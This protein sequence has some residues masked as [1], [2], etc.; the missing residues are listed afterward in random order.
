MSALLS[1]LLSLVLGGPELSNVAW[2]PVPPRVS[3]LDVVDEPEVWLGERITFVGQVRGSLDT[4][5][6]FVTP[7]QSSR[8]HGLTLWPDESLLWQREAYDAPGLP[9]F[10]PRQGRWA[11]RSQALRPHERVLM[12]GRVRS[13]L[14]G[15]PW[16]EIERVIR[17]REHVP[18]GSVLHAIRAAELVRKGAVDLARAEALR[19]LAAPLPAAPRGHLQAFERSCGRLLERLERGWRPGTGELT[20]QHRAILALLQDGAPSA[21]SASWRRRLGGVA[22]PGDPLR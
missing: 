17:T 14:G 10:V 20:R 13:C 3:L 16:I 4:W 12:T 18:E 9:V 15:R 21:A 5:E 11:A 22:P 7:F 19:A 6:G 1:L 8:H 2:E